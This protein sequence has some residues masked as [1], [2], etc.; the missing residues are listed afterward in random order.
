[1]SDKNSI[2]RPKGLD[3]DWKKHVGEILRKSGLVGSDF[4]GTIELSLNS[5]GV[6]SVTKKETYR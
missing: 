5:G 6:A 1:M 2:R 4:T 3:A